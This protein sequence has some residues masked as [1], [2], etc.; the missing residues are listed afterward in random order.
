MG[1]S[2]SSNKPLYY[3]L[4]VIAILVIVPLNSGANT[5]DIISPNNSDPIMDEIGNL[6]FNTETELSN[7]LRSNVDRTM[8]GFQAGFRDNPDIDSEVKY[9]LSSSQM[10]MG[11]SESKVQLRIPNF[12]DEHEIVPDGIESSEK[13]ISN[14]IGYTD[15]S[16]E[17]VGSNPVKPIS[18]SP[19][20]TYF[21]YFYGSDSDKWVTNAP[22]YGKVVY[23][24]IY[25]N[26]DLIY[27]IK[28][29]QLKY[30]FYVYPGGNYE[31]IQ[32]RWTGPISITQIDDGLQVRIETL[33][34]EK[35]VIDGNPINFLGT[36]QGD[37]IRGNFRFIDKNSYGFSIDNYDHSQTLIIDPILEFSTFIGG[38][39]LDIGISLAIDS[40][41]NIYITG[42][43][44][45]DTINYPT[46]P[47]AFDETHNGGYY[48][49]FVTKLAANGSTLLF[50]T[51]LGGTSEDI[52][53]AIALDNDNNV[54][55]TG[56][57]YSTDFPI[58]SE[59]FDPSYNGG[60]AFITKLAS[61][62]SSL[63][64]SSFIGSG[65]GHSIAINSNNDVFITGDTPLSNFPT[66]ADA[67]DKVHNGDLD[68]FV[69]KLAANFSTLIFSTFIGG[70]EFDYG[71][72]LVIDN[73]ENIIIT[74]YS[75]SAD[76]PTTT[77]SFGI[78]YEG[79]YDTIVS[80][81]DSEG[82][83]LQ[84]STFVGGSADDYGCGIAIDSNND[85][86]I[87]G[88]TASTD[89]PTTADAYN[90]VNHGAEDVFV[91]KLS[92]DLASLIFSTY[93]GGLEDEMG[94]SIVIN[95][96]NEIFVTGYTLSTNFPIS[97]GAYDK[98]HNGVRDVFVLAL[99]ANGSIILF[100]SFIGGT[101]E[102]I[103]YSIKID[104][105]NALYIT[106]STVDGATDFPSTP[107]AYDDTH[108]GG[109]DI[110][111][112]KIIGL[113][114]NPPTNITSVSNE[115]GN[116]IFLV[117]DA[118]PNNIISLYTAYKIYRGTSSGVYSYLGSSIGSQTYYND[119]T[120][121]ADQDYYYVVT[122]TNQFGEGQYSSEYNTIIQSIS[123]PTAPINVYASPGGNFVDLSWS[124]SIDDGGSAVIEYK[125][126]R[127]TSQGIYSM[128]FVSTLTEFNDTTV[129]GC[130]T[131]YYVI[132]AV[133]AIGEGAYSSEVSAAIPTS[134]PP[135][136][137]IT[138]I[139][140]TTESSTLTETIF[141]I[142]DLSSLSQDVESNFN[143]LAFL[144]SIFSIT[145]IIRRRKDK[146]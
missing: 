64:L 54:Y 99:S 96:N 115:K 116:Y 50:S 1:F 18:E 32:L 5:F 81:L 125:I 65:T 26:I 83:I 34:S 72:S 30:D 95:D 102:D 87:T 45:I 53:N 142:S 49:I 70:S 59:V 122:T 56:T 3:T 134:V 17:F 109:N 23:E 89:F 48:D 61:N 126:Y 120:I 40:S 104:H 8:S 36:L 112:V 144:V 145:F 71:R 111:V 22:S 110:F 2:K 41:D 143:V 123:E 12:E 106:G 77:G 13:M 75:N 7:E 15:V 90:T 60:D 141:T 84:S 31:D 58:T 74:G 88:E 14:I 66:T 6:D 124:A 131:Y 21:N 132:T 33:N 4:M 85:V 20:F 118:N 62:G 127:G 98:T 93:I 119:T 35:S 55:L 39:G 76:F 129:D 37:E 51:F 29:G 146:V 136:N 101:S 121:V 80:K 11:F 105:T 128:I 86:Y 140:T 82:S 108:N 27:S 92:E 73:N 10:D 67:Y 38:S 57:T 43:T 24:N 44:V 114:P 97:V 94:N 100:S 78:I 130:I 28:N 19:S 52:A 42:I 9:I 16:L 113:I 63:I 91:T 68:I 79:G 107:N 133:N 47:D 135:T 137:T 69:T 138:E 46:T 103:A 139:S 117:W 25:D